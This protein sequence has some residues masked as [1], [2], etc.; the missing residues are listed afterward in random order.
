MPAATLRQEGGG[1]GVVSPHHR[2]PSAPLEN[3]AAHMLLPFPS[4]GLSGCRGLSCPD[5][6]VHPQMIATPNHDRRPLW[7]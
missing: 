7:K 4:F 2:I 5:Q 3:A 6:T 1:G